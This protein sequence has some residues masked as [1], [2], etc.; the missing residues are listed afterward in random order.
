M[1]Y[2]I[3]RDK[4]H[5]LSLADLFVLPEPELAFYNNSVDNDN[6]SITRL[7]R[8]VITKVA[9]L[10]NVI[11]AADPKGYCCNGAINI[12]VDMHIRALNVPDSADEVL[13]RIREG[14]LFYNER[15]FIIHR[16]VVRVSTTGKFRISL[17]YERVR[18]D[19]QCFDTLLR[20]HLIDSFLAENA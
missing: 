18:A 12:V 8:E 14:F 1:R 13:Q 20:L 9:D 17:L 11:F 19:Q 15:Q 6:G 7:V 2:S 3:S 5:N 10:P 4:Q 16:F